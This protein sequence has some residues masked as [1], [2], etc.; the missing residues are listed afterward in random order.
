VT[1]NPENINIFFPVPGQDND[2]QVFRDNFST[3]QSSLIDAKTRIE[4]IED[5]YASLSREE[6]NNF[7]LKEIKNAVF[8]ETR[9]KLH[10]GE[11]PNTSSFEIDWMNGSYQ[12]YRIGENSTTITFTNLPGDSNIPTENTAPKSVGRLTLELYSNDDTE[13]TI[14]FNTIGGSEFRKNDSSE[15]GV[16]INPTVASITVSS[17][18]NPVFIEVWRRTGPSDQNYIFLRYLGQYA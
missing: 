2:T 13:K 11:S 16:T 17:S 7:N 12:I 18:E 8:V 3:I 4:A 1:M 15:W 5:D 6:G 9:E 14:T 10:N